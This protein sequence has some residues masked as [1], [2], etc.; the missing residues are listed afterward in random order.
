MAGRFVETFTACSTV[1]IKLTEGMECQKRT[2]I[3]YK[4]PGENIQ[5]IITYQ[6][7]CNSFMGHSRIQETAVAI[8]TAYT[9]GRIREFDSD[10]RQSH[11]VH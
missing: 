4:F 10:R 5:T 11:R 2:E 1:P 7:H 6:L 3:R 9:C 8:K